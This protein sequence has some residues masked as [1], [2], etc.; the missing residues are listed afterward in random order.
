MH[1]TVLKTIKVYFPWIATISSDSVY[2]F[3]C[4]TLINLFGD[5]LDAEVSIDFE[6]LAN[7]RQNVRKCI[8][9]INEKFFTK[10]MLLNSLCNQVVK[11]FYFQYKTSHFIYFK[12]RFDFKRKATERLNKLFFFANLA[13]PFVSDFVEQWLTSEA[14]SSFWLR[15]MTRR[16]NCMVS[17]RSSKVH[18]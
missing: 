12:V 10:L 6:S 5:R 15:L 9:L 11:Q 16:S 17:C 7:A 8:D 18:S 14:T 1:I 4:T 13:T 3:C 2:I